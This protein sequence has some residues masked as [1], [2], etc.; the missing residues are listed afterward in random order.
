MPARLKTAN[1]TC[2]RI[3]IFSIVRHLWHAGF[4]SPTFR[5]VALPL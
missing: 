1:G 2:L 4:T 3:V 5:K